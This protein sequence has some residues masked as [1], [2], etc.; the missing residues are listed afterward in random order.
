M[1]WD[2]VQARQVADIRPNYRIVKNFNFLGRFD[3][4]FIKNADLFAIYRGWYDAL[5]DIKHKGRAEPDGFWTNY[6][7]DYMFQHL[8]T[9]QNDYR[10]NDL[11]EYYLQADITDSLSF[12]IGKQQVIWTEADALSGTELINSVDLR[13][14]WTH[15]ENPEDIRRAVQMVKMNYNLP[16]FYG[17]SN[18]TLEAFW[19]PG[20][21]QGGGGL[22]NVN[23]P[24]NPWVA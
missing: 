22:V 18:N 11:R 19:I 8:D 6:S 7:N 17:T 23:D 12:R 20:D 2:L 9:I 15:F 16:D 14:H 3:T 21:Y 13:Y 1:H 4:L 5:P 10:R 24:R